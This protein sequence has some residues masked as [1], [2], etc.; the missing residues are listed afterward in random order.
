MKRG[1]AYRNTAA[2]I[3][4]DAMYSPLAAVRIASCDV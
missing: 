1:K 4:K 2:K 3:D